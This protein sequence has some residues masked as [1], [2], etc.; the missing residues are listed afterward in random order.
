MSDTKISILA[1]G[2]AMGVF[3]PALAVKN[4]L[5]NLG[6]KSEVLVL[7]SLIIEEK[8]NKINQTKKI[9]HKNFELAKVGHRMAK[10]ISPNLD[11]GLL[12]KLFNKWESEDCKHFIVFSGF[13]LP[14]LERY[15]EFTRNEQIF[16]D[17]VIVDSDISPSWKSYKGNIDK[18]F[19]YIMIFDAQNKKIGP[20]LFIPKEP[21]V[22][23]EE[24]E[25]RI[26]AH[27]GGW[28]MGTYQNKISEL[29]SAGVD[30]NIM[31]YS[32]EDLDNRSSENKYF[33][34][35]PSWVPWGK[36]NM[37]GHTENLVKDI[38][39]PPFAE[40][41][42]DKA[43]VFSNRKEYHELFY[44]IERSKGIISKPG[45]ST[46]V[47]SLASA[48]P[49][50]FVD[51]LGEHEERNAELWIS[52]GFGISYNEWKK[53]GFLLDILQKLNK[54]LLKQRESGDSYVNSY[55]KRR[56]PVLNLGIIGCSRIV[57][58]A[59]INPL[60]GIKNICVYGIASRKIENAENYAKKY[61]IKN[62]FNGYQELLECPDIDFVYIALP[63][64]LHSE[65]V[66][67][68]ANA[69]KHVLVEKPIC[70]D[71]VELQIMEKACAK[72][73]VFLLEALMIQHHPWQKYIKDL[74]VNKTYGN[75]IGTHTKISFTPKDNFKNNY[76]SDPEKGGGA[77]YDLATYWLYIMQCIC[78]ITKAEYK[79]ESAFNGPN[80][81]DW[82]FDVTMKSDESYVNKFCASFEKPYQAVL[83]M[84]FEGGILIMDDFFRA[85]LGKY[86]ININL[87]DKLSGK[88]EKIT[89]P[90]QCYYT[91][92]LLF[93]YDVICGVKKNVA[94]KESADRLT[95][96]NNVYR[97]AERK[98]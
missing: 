62:V 74:I 63:N 66:Q 17:L 83:E 69:G 43:P 44:V 88:T 25:N 86:K 79:A 55:I 22:H 42:G 26:V 65:W 10:D 33:M 37:D 92:Q 61:S 30:L 24:R 70:I 54:N 18:E 5:E 20:K 53:T 75:L 11:N 36:K 31:I 59:V 91:N 38:E 45:G 27:G 57:P 1:S 60:K 12:N 64:H 81:C 28:G 29:N 13:W 6:M 80:G 15:K 89:F 58:R 40:I 52:L 47:D 7:E 2:V 49:I 50:I 87:K 21:V 71:I 76:R 14:V 78:D 8:R 4:Q 48:T 9:F 77:F 94:I 95:I 82:T 39:F 67:K 98:G 51:A 96:I 41:K 19:D 73:N 3:I 90:P 93:F 32:E 84:E 85:N 34:V 68:A 35:D 16:A 23:F 56:H 72:N 97:I 46:L